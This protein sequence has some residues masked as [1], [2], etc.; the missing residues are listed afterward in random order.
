[1]LS[2]TLTDVQVLNSHLINNTGNGL[3]TNSYVTVNGLAITGTVM[4]DNAN[5]AYI[6]GP[7]T[8]LKQRY[9]CGSRYLWPQF[10]RHD[11]PKRV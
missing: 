10:V 2:G 11:R 4:S 7:T 6:E 3:N 8:N 1:V 5:G 9:G